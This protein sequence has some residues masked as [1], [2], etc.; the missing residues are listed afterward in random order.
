MRDHENQSALIID[1]SV[2]NN[3][4]IN[5]AEREKVTK[6]QFLKVVLKEEWNL[7][8]ID[9]IPVNIGATGLMKD[10]REKCLSSIP[11]NP[12]KYEV[13]TAAIRGTV[14][15]LKRVLGSNFQH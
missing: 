8:Q 10:S 6:Y 2:P 5:R 14:S 1:A 9:I 4:G 13:Q 12:N 3:F 7:K 11:G 15:I